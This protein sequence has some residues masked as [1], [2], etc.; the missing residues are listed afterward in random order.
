[1]DG[2]KTQRSEIN[3]DGIVLESIYNYKGMEN[4][5]IIYFDIE[6]TNTE[7]CRDLMYTGITRA[8]DAI[9]LFVNE[10]SKKILVNWLMS[11]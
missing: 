9:R 1:V 11:Y 5:I 6:V 7:V 4:K 3:S 2:S 8:T 10:T